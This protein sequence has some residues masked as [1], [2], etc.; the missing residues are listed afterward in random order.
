MEF[1][2][3]INKVNPCGRTIGVLAVIARQLLRRYKPGKNNPQVEDSQDSQA[4]S[5][6][7]VSFE[8]P[9][10]KLP[11]GSEIVTVWVWSLKY[12]HHHVSDLLGF[13]ISITNTGI[14]PGKQD[15]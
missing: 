10:H 11:L 8:F 6:Q 1:S 12:F 14:Q 15:V 5:G 3:W 2:F 4:D 13:L 7:F 9:A